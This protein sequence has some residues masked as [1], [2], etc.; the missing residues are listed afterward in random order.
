MLDKK[1]TRQ[2]FERAADSYDA[3]AVLQQEVAK[4][5]AERLDYIKI[6]PK[7]ALDIGC[8][9]GNFLAIAAR[10]V[11]QPIGVDIAMRWLHL[12]RRRFL[13][14]GLEVPALVCCCAEYLPFKPELFDAAV[15]ASTFEFLRSPEE[16]L[17]ELKRTLDADESSP[18]PI[19]E[20][21]T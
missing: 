15:I 11:E 14:D 8:G 12:S 10:H 17:I 18:L 21:A 4:R 7:H 6:N 9:T 5:L 1:I 2:H 20:R 3:A 19:K 16:A 13:D